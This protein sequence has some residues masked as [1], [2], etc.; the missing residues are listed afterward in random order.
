MLTPAHFKD[1]S[2]FWRQCPDLLLNIGLQFVFPH[3]VISWRT[4]IL[5]KVILKRIDM[6]DLYLLMDEQVKY[7]IP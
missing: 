4:G 2:H 6:P 7:F 1:L 3:P 5:T